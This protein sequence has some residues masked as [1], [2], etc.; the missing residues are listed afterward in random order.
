MA[1]KDLRYTMS[2][3]DRLSPA[4]K[5]AAVNYKRSSD[6]I[7]NSSKKTSDVIKNSTS[8]MMKGYVGLVASLAGVFIAY[9][10]LSSFFSEATE[11][12]K[13]QLDAEQK[14]T[15]S[16]GY[17]SRALK[18]Y[19]SEL[20]KASVYGDEVV[21]SSMSQIAAFIKEEDQI[22]KIQKA[23]LD[24]AS[25]KN[26]DL[27]S[28]TDLLVKS[29]SSGTNALSRYGIQMKKS[30]SETVRAESLLKN[31]DKAFGGVASAMA[32][33]DSGKITQAKNAI[34]DL[35]EE[36]GTGLLPVVRD[37]YGLMLKMSKTV[38]P[39]VKDMVRGLKYEFELMTGKT[40]IAM[41]KVREEM[42]LIKDLPIGEQASLLFD[43]L[44]KS[45]KALESIK[46]ETAGI[47]LASQSAGAIFAPDKK[48]RI[49]EITEQVKLYKEALKE[50]TNE[51][52]KIASLSEK[53]DS[54]IPTKQSS[55]V[56]SAMKNINSD[57]AKIGKNAREK[58]MIDIELWY[59]EQKVLFRGNKET[60]LKL[61][62]I[63][64]DKMLLIQQDYTEKE[65]TLNEEKVE[66]AKETHREFSKIG[67][68]ER[69]K[70]LMDIKFWYD[71]QLELLKE[72]KVAQAELEK[73]YLD[74]RL[75]VYKSHA[76]EERRL[77]QDMV[78]N[79]TKDY[80]MLGRSIGQALGV[81]F[82]GQKASVKEAF[83]GVL[84]VT[85]DFL[86]KQVIAAVIGNQLKN[87]ATL[88]PVGLLKAAGETALITGIFSVAKAGI[89]SF[90][91]G[92]KVQK[93]PGIPATGDRTPIYA[94][95]GEIVLNRAQQRNLANQG[96]NKSYQ[97]TIESTNINISGN[98]SQ[99]TLSEID[100]TLQERNE[101]L[102][103]QLFELSEQGRLS[104]IAF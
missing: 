47:Q 37:W 66:I 78:K 32:K 20:Q 31:I 35:K 70:E 58:E 14:L 23:A 63:Y 10:K 38:F 98:V 9:R 34:G 42:N 94:D 16:I 26:M 55:S 57:F 71:E 52:Q 103:D 91:Y 75:E 40:S 81:G 80:L 72:N 4:S 93:Q 39:A 99:D 65:K 60:L 92:G 69:D 3:K 2:L 84:G 48:Q 21:I 8:S 87:F 96:G 101:D 83:K 77:D 44:S 95:P 59:A 28:A 13:V 56:L 27:I 67:M 5:N 74:K 36:I 12:A 85:V 54:A 41:I 79:R 100:K 11:L 102:R 61:D 64:A 6:N 43:K 73:L 7:S 45:K 90:Q 97:V 50:V 53:G 86:E 51:T 62:G 22:K 89:Q 104:G 76:A 88:G 33:T 25:A 18:A 17:K 15:A 82:S 30:N 49:S 46:K 24:L 68:S 1:G 29:I 19:A